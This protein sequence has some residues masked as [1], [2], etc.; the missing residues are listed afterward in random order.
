MEMV[1]ELVGQPAPDLA[2]LPTGPEPANGAARHL[3]G[4]APIIAACVGPIVYFVYVNHYAV[5]VPQLDEWLRVRMLHAAIHGHLTLGMLWAPYNEA[6]ILVDNLIYVVS[7]LVDHYDI[8]TLIIFNAAVFILTFWLL[9]ALVRSFQG[10]WPGAISI[11]VISAIWFNLA[12]VQNPLTGIPAPYLLLLFLVAMIWLL[13][14]PTRCRNICLGV[15]V[16]LAVAASLTTLEGFALWLLGL[17]CLLWD[18]QAVRRKYV[19][20]SVWIAAAVIT[21]AVY[22]YRFKLSTGCAGRLVKHC[23]LHYAVHHPVEAFRFLLVLIGNVVP[24]GY[25]GAIFSPP[26]K[27][28]V[29]QESLGLIILVAAVFVVVQTVRHRRAGTLPLPLLL[30]VFALLYD[31]L[32]VE[33]RS[34]IG[35][36][37]VLSGNRYVLPN[38][39]LVLGIFVYALA[40]MPGRDPDPGENRWRFALRWS[41]I[42]VLAV[43]LLAQLA[44]AVPFGRHN[45]FLTKQS[46]VSFA[47]TLV[48]LDRY[49]RSELGCVLSWALTSNLAP[50]T[51]AFH[52]GLPIVKDART[53]RL[54][55]FQPG[56][57]RMYRAAGPVPLEVMGCASQ[58]GTN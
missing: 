27:H 7:A 18:H 4:L 12:D 29:R 43:F 53:D 15:A 37:G 17:I 28:F 50:P 55:I 23:S 26:P 57:Y 14:V 19:E 30:I 56:E 20:Y 25:L 54:A 51:L 16:F 5:D 33:G 45:G 13:C 47:R 10:K 31:L 22:F 42:G 8:R 49:P 36:A 3:R 9:L 34:S 52:Q 6:R 58:S 44:V 40:H 38:L 48:N 46:N 21:S 41:A 2:L 11:L 1:D 32:I 39:L 35:L 24:S